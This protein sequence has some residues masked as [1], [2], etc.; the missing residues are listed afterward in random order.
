[1]KI[2]PY[3]TPELRNESDVVIQ[4]GTYGDLEIFL[5][6][7]S[8]FKKSNYSYYSYE[9]GGAYANTSLPTGINVEGKSNITLVATLRYMFYYVEY[10]RETKDNDKS[11]IS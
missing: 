11:G 4:V 9:S 10:G 1:M 3:Q 8:I 6:G 5:D 7:Q 2:S